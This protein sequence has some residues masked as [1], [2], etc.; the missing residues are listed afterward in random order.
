MLQKSWI[1]KIPNFLNMDSKKSIEYLEFL[2]KN[3]E[4][5]LELDNSI[6]SLLDYFNYVHRHALN[7][8]SQ[9]EMIQVTL[10]VK[11]FNG[12]NLKKFSINQIYFS[13]FLCPFAIISS[14]H[15][16]EPR[17]SEDITDLK[18]IHYFPKISK[19]LNQSI[20]YIENDIHLSTQ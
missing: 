16:N 17:Y 14:V 11:K 19:I 8:L 13:Y 7:K 9:R 3:K 15:A 2:K 20:V 12:F 18:I 6:P 5:K 10:A 4:A 1:E